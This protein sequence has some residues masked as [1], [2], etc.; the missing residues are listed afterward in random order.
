M[1]MP[2][3]RILIGALLA[4][5]L[6]QTIPAAPA[7]AQPEWGR[8]TTPEE[9]R[10]LNTTIERLSAQLN[11]RRE[12][13]QA[14][15]KALGVSLRNTSFDRLIQL[16]ADRAQE[17]AVLRTRLVELESR[18]RSLPPGAVTLEAQRT[19]QRAV[20]AFNDGR[21]EVAQAEFGHLAVL[22]QS[23]S[24]EALTAWS[25]A[26]DAQARIAE[27]RLD[28]DTAASL[29]LAAAEQIRRSSVILQWNLSLAAAN[30]Y[31]MRGIYLDDQAAV[32]RAIATL[33]D[34]V[35]PLVPKA[36]WPV[37]WANTQVGLGIAKATLGWT[38][39]DRALLESAISILDSGLAGLPRDRD[40]EQW[41]RAQAALATAHGY[42]GEASGDLAH[43]NQ[44]VDSLRTV[45]ATL[46]KER[47]PLL[48]AA[49]QGQLA[50]MLTLVGGTTNRYA[51]Q[52]IL[53]SFGEAA[54]FFR[55]QGMTREWA[56]MR[57]GLA[58]A[59]LYLGLSQNSLP[60]LEQALSIYK[61]VEPYRPKSAGPLSWAAIQG[62]IGFV[63]LE[64][65]IRTNDP[66]RLRDA[67][68]GFTRAL[69][70]QTEANGPAEFARTQI[71]MGFAYVR[72]ALAEHDSSHLDTALHHLQAA[73][74][75]VRKIR[76]EA[77]EKYLT[78]A[79]LQLTDASGKL[80]PPAR[81]PER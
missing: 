66:Q 38:T 76:Q 74:P 26:V 20:S 23:G 42:L 35:L 49:A 3:G 17:A 43:L 58:N 4:I 41:A 30:A 51:E 36:E 12:T 45:V 28:F 19:L 72:L 31:L 60:R 63:N 22:R 65:G 56:G 77:L 9:S 47:F 54:D 21:L 75:V 68:G 5:A 44:A 27:L 32:K 24:M 57:S 7:A 62:N 10:R 55:A 11:V 64:L 50:T 71:N 40:L 8:P 69:E 81:A 73:I 33:E 37:E 52:E 16:V 67:I 2:R 79:I 46:P 80:E 39:A 70:E 18:L 25:Q 29:R 15:A 14:I 34:V 13:L 48:R 53:D 61:E 6:A 59:L 1:K 78:D